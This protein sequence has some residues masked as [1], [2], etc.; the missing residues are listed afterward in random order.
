[1]SVPF[2]HVLV[3]HEANPDGQGDAREEGRGQPELVVGMEGHFR[4]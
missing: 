1:M 3:L 4:Q 2:V